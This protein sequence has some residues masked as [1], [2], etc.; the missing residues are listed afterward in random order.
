MDNDLRIP[1]QNIEAEASVLSAMML[2]KDALEMA[3]EK[4]NSETFYKSSHRSI[5][6]AMVNMF[7]SGTDVDMIALID[8]IKNNNMIDQ[9]GGYSYLTGVYNAAASSANIETHIEIIKQKS[10]LRNIIK[11]STNIIASAYDESNDPKDVLSFAE[12]AIF[13]ISENSLEHD[14]RHISF[15]NDL[16]DINYNKYNETQF[17]VGINSLDKKLR[18]FKGM[19]YVFAG[20][21]GGGKSS[22]IINILL[23]TSRSIPVGFFS[24]EMSGDM[25]NLRS[26]HTI[27]P[28]TQQGYARYKEGAQKLKDR[29]L[30]IDETTALSEHQLRTKAFKM[31]KKYNVQ[32]F[33]LDYIQ[34][35]EGTGMSQYEKETNISKAI[36][37]LA[38]ETDT[39]WLIISQMKKESYRQRNRNMGDV[40]GSGQIIQDARGIYFVEQNEDNPNIIDFWCAKQSYGEA[41]WNESLYFDKANNKFDEISKTDT[42]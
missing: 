24:Q 33:A 22:L 34:L 21:P 25:V 39:C 4:L 14:A 11:E 19:P 16:V 26:A 2:D 35:A 10:L 15:F 20:L 40:K 37:N 27:G 17:P 1:P 31:I 36:K 5:F 7:K 42:W 30:Y 9:V 29:M 3:I 13:K 38:K 8:Y 6:G 23:N 28:R 12:R 32:L 18:L 41:S